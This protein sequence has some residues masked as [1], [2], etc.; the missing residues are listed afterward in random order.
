MPGHT[1]T[2]TVSGRADQ[3][4]E[5]DM[6]EKLDKII[7]FAIDREHEAAEFYKELQ[8]HAAFKG[9]LE[10]LKEYEAMERGHAKLLES[11]RD[12]FEEK[13]P[14]INLDTLKMS[15][16]LEEPEQKDEMTFQDI[17]LIAMKR[18]ERALNLYKYLAENSTSE[19][20]RKIFYRLAEEEARHKLHF[21]K[22]YE[23]EVLIDN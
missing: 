7:S 8:F 2:C 14:S 12:S 22:L 13:R 11:M 4:G 21:E 16:Y 6:D 1:V 19:D 23:D 15:D 20:T 9:Q 5:I 17:V 18:E 10:M 3:S